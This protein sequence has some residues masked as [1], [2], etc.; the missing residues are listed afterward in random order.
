MKRALFGLIWFFAF[1]IGGIAT[2]GAVAGYTAANTTK[3]SNFSEGARAGDAAGRHVGAKYGGFVILGALVLAVIGA[4][5]RVLPGT[6]G[7]IS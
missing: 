3:A 6:K 5:A 1:A 7:R 4:A 2:M